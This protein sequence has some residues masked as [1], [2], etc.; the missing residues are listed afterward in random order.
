[1]YNKLF[2]CFTL[3]TKNE[4]IKSKWFSLGGGGMSCFIFRLGCFTINSLLCVGYVISMVFSFDVVEWSS[5]TSVLPSCSMYQMCVCWM[6]SPRP[7][8]CKIIDYYTQPDLYLEELFA[9]LQCLFFFLSVCKLRKMNTSRNTR[10]A[11][12]THKF[13]F[14][15]INCWIP[16]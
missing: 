10:R 6:Q 13:V 5:T 9:I 11:N 2:F 3:P 12:E 1:M 7:L 8:Y 14:T 15:Q 4:Q 16:R